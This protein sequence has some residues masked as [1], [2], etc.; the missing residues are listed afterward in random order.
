M[1]RAIRKKIPLL[2]LIVISLSW[3]IYYQSNSFLND[4]GRANFEWLFLIDG[5]L[6]LPLLCMLC[7]KDK[8]QAAIKAVL[9]CC[10][11]V[12]V[13]SIIIPET[14]KHFWP[15]LESGRY[16]ILSAF[17]LAEIVTV[18][19]V[20]ISIRSA[21]KQDI[22]PD[23]AVSSPIKRFIGE[24]V[25]SDIVCFEARVWSY[26]LF[27][28]A[29]VYERF[30]GEQHFSY[31]QKDGAQSNSTGFIF[32]ILFEA[33]L[34]HLVLHFLWSPVGASVITALTLLSLVFFFAENRA[35]SRRPISI[36]GENLIIRYGVYNSKVIRLTNIKSVN[37]NYELIPRSKSVKRFNF[38]GRPNIVI[39]LIE[40][41]GDIEKVYL[42]VDFPQRFINVINESQNC[43]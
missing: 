3:G 1:S 10:A 31:H 2:F 23:I 16:L 25:Y 34:M 13:G 24:G 4:F 26:A 33:P 43:I 22:D 41:D 15:Y 29:I 14:S 21:F 28:K 8:K 18:S 7:I 19:I 17:I 20:V 37:E 27:S 36:S 42:G 39:H 12:F 35:M 40:P 38:A 6:V 5:L 9:Y 30:R 32:L 11:I